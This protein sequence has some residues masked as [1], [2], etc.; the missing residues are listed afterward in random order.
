METDDRVTTVLNFIEEAL[1]EI[2]E[3]DGAINSYNIHLNVSKCFAYPIR[4]THYYS[5][6]RRGYL[7]YPIPEP[8][9]PSA[10]SEPEGIAKGVRRSSGK[11]PRNF[12]RLTNVTSQQTVHVDRE[13]LLMLTNQSLE[14]REGLS[15]LEDAATELYKALQ[16]GKD[17]GELLRALKM[18]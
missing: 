6:R 5:V 1:K 10:N 18:T 8:R 12:I 9:T 17:T 11:H 14:K 2:E 15:R 3:M 13:A 4:V 7:L 16:A